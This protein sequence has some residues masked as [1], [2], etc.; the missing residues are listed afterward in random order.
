MLAPGGNA[1]LVAIRQNDP[2]GIMARMEKR[3]GLACD[4]N[5]KKLPFMSQSEKRYSHLV[6]RL[7]VVLDR[8]AGREHL[9]VLR[10]TRKQDAT[11]T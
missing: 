9:S 3:F 10:F 1:Y 2:R 5:N 4:V 6:Y 11:A 7:Q 8:R